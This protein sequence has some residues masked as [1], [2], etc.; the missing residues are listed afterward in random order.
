MK[1]TLLT[2]AFVSALLIS[3]K[4]KTEDKVDE[5]ADAVGTEMSEAVDSA[6]IKMDAAADSAAV[7]VEN[8]V[9]AGAAKVEEAAK[10]VKE[11]AK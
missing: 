1:K 10:D 11:S 3:C 5:A 6:A 9:E 2:L 8:A 4:E 7:K